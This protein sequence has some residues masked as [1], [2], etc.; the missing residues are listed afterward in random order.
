M[1]IVARITLSSAPFSLAGVAPIIL[2][3]SG[4]GYFYDPVLGDLLLDIRVSGNGAPP[5][6]DEAAYF[7][8]NIGDADGAFSRAHNF[9][10]GFEDSGLQTQFISSAVAVPEPGTIVLVT[11]GLV[12]IAVRRR[13]KVRDPAA[14]AAGRQDSAQNACV[15]DRSTSA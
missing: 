8:A 1:R 9:G 15:A 7:R 2:S 6:F 12:A 5:R 11:T 14:V 10:A 4:F 3:F 13:R